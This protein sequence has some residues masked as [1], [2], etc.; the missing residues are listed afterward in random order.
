MLAVRGDE[1]FSDFLLVIAKLGVRLSV[2]KLHGQG[3]ILEK[4]NSEKLQRDQDSIS[5]EVEVNRFE[6]IKHIDVS[7]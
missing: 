3:C 4:V 2:I 6:P 7:P 1:C 5:Y